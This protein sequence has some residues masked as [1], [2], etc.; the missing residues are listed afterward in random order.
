[1]PARENTVEPHRAKGKK[2]DMRLGREHHDSRQGTH[3]ILRGV[4]MH[5]VAGNGE[6]QAALQG[7]LL[8]WSV[9]C[10]AGQ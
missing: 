8:L 9:G 1:M 6:P 5:N 4:L 3:L 2:H 7:R 10:S